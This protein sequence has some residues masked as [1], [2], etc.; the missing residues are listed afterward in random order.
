MN[1]ERLAQKMSKVIDKLADDDKQKVIRTLFTVPSLKNER[2]MD[3]LMEGLTELQKEA[4]GKILAL[5]LEDELAQEKLD[6]SKQS[7]A[8]VRQT[9]LS[10][11]QSLI[12]S[13]HTHHA[14]SDSDLCDRAL[15]MAQR[16]HDAT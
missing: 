3:L 4:V 15:K 13:P 2:E 1:Q 7:G 8:E 9:A 5:K 12:A 16:L 14:T 11:L 6:K 10:I